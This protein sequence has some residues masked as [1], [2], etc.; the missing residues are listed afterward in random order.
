M[1]RKR[2]N[3]MLRKATRCSVR[4]KPDDEGGGHQMLRKMQR[5]KATRCEE[6]KATRCYRKGQ[7]EAEE[8]GNMQRNIVE[9]HLRKPLLTNA[10]GNSQ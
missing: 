2:G 5:K 7:P 10:R 3:Q 8:E 4:G 9:L 1:L 6:K